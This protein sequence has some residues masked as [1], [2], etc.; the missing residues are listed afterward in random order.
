MFPTPQDEIRHFIG[1]TLELAGQMLPYQAVVAHVGNIPRHMREALHEDFGAGIVTDS[2]LF[3]EASFDIGRPGSAHEG[4]LL[5]FEIIVKPGAPLSFNDLEA[6]FGSW[7]RSPPEPTECAFALACFKRHDVSTGA[8]F[9]LY[10]EYNPNGTTIPAD[11][12]PARLFFQMTDGRWG[13][14]DH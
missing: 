3:S 10:A 7:Y 2:A 8:P 14:H 5:T 1:K 11:G 4:M 12:F 9:S 13:G 6:V